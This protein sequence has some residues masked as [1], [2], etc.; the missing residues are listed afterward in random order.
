VTA[1]RVAFAAVVAALAVAAVPGGAGAANEC[2]G[3]PRCIPVEGPWVSVPASGEV[4]F[5]LSCPQGKG[6]VAGTDGQA[7]SIDIRATFDGILASPVS[8]GRTTHTAALFRALS[9][10]HRPGAF[11][12]F[13]GCIPAP[14]AVR[15]TIAAQVSPVGP[16]LDYV[17]RII[18]LNPGFQRIVTL[19]CPLGE[20]LVD[21]W[22]ATAFTT[23]KPPPPAVASAIAVTS[24]VVGGRVQLAITASEA[25]PSGVR[26]EVQ[27]GV[28]CAA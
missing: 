9:A 8:F 15:N 18:K 1:A 20:S 27:I 4:K 7:S 11:K 22:S 2:A 26:A 14:S 10:H 24:K 19:A 16:P 5:V 25:L 3:I 12:P 23:P 6:V 13:I 21:S 17:G 28:R